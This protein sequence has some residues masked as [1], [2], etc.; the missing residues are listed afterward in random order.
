VFHHADANDRD[1]SWP[2]CLS[3]AH[4]SLYELCSPP[5]RT[6]GGPP[7]SATRSLSADSNSTSEPSSSVNR[8]NS[9][10]T[11]PPRPAP[12]PPA[13]RHA[14]P[15]APTADPRIRSVDVITVRYHFIPAI[16]FVPLA[17][18]IMCTHRCGGTCDPA[19]SAWHALAQQNQA[20]R[21]R[22]ALHVGHPDAPPDQVGYVRCAP[23]SGQLHNVSR[24]H[25]PRHP[26]ARQ[27]RSPIV[28][29]GA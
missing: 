21:V 6:S 13:N 4:R 26:G 5:S 28:R 29:G 15:P 20:V 7:C 14:H 22:F 11:S 17:G 12:G 18:A 19:V 8:T 24:P 10:T 3:A 23:M 27:R 1:S 2:C 25:Q 16:A 9:A